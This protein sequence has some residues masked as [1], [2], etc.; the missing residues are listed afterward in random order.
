MFATLNVTDKGFC[1]RAALARADLR[2]LRRTRYNGGQTLGQGLRRC[3]AIKQFRWPS[4][5]QN[6]DLHSGLDAEV[7]VSAFGL[8]IA[9]LG[10]ARL[11][12]A[13]L[14]IAGRATPL[15]LG[16]RCHCIGG[17]ARF[18]GIRRETSAKQ[19]ACVRHRWHRSSG[20]RPTPPAIA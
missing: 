11:G 2:A 8:G 10:I 14:G 17:S 5:R 20:W 18:L 12:I 3:H 7:A 16:L 19:L 6:G 9:R 4:V 15:T 13:G 1:G